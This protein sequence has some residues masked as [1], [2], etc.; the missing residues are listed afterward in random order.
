[1]THDGMMWGAMGCWI[2]LLVCCFCFFFFFKGGGGR[3]SSFFFGGFGWG[4]WRFVG[5]GNLRLVVVG[6]FRARQQAAASRGLLKYSPTL[7]KAAVVIALSTSKCYL[8][9][10]V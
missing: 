7:T 5:E 3:G 8:N 10:P 1:M 6:R 9:N 4:I 2:L